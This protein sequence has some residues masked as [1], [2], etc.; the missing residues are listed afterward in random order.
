MHTVRCS[1]M[2]A[3]ELGGVAE[4]KRESSGP[5]RLE[6]TLRLHKRSV[7]YGILCALLSLVCCTSM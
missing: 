5:S 4:M 7:Q 6:Y 2:L 3:H 1:S